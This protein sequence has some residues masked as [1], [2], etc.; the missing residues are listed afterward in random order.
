MSG[1]TGHI[2]NDEEAIKRSMEEYRQELIKNGWKEGDDGYKSLMG[3]HHHFIVTSQEELEKEWAEI[4]ALGIEGPT[5]EEY[6]ES[7][8]PHAMYQKGYR[9]GAL[10]YKGLVEEYLKGWVAQIKEKQKENFQ[11]KFEV[12]K[13]ELNTDEGKFIF[14]SPGVKV[15]EEDINV[16]PTPI[17]DVIEHK[18]LPQMQ[19]IFDNN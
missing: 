17:E 12:K 1:S 11:Q 5:V 15:K 6:F 14:I 2:N 3:L 9:E 18:I 8:N 4:E 7:T 10:R 16:L 19:E 13:I